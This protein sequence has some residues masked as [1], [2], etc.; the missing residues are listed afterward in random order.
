MMIFLMIITYFVFG[1]LI[2]SH[3]FNMSFE[4]AL[5]WTWSHFIDPGFISLDAT[6]I[7][8]R[9]FGSIFAILGMILVA[10]TIVNFI[11]NVTK[12]ILKEYADGHL[13][14]SLDNDI[15]VIGDYAKLI[16]FLKFDPRPILGLQSHVD[17]ILLATKTKDFEILRAAMDNGNDS[18]NK[19]IYH[20]S[21]EN[22]NHKQTLQLT[23]LST[24]I[25]FE[26][27][28]DNTGLMIGMIESIL[29]KRRL[30]HK[31]NI[32]INII[33]ESAKSMAILDLY[34][35]KNRDSLNENLMTITY[36]NSFVMNTRYFIKKS[37]FFDLGYLKMQEPIDFL[38]VIDGKNLFALEFLMQFLSLG[39]YHIKNT[40]INII[41]HDNDSFEKMIKSRIK[42]DLEVDDYAKKMIDIQ[43]YA[44][45]EQWYSSIMR[46]QANINTNISFS[47]FNEN[48]DDVV[49]KYISI[50]F[51]IKNINQAYTNLNQKLKVNSIFLQLSDDS[52]YR[53]Q[54]ELFYLE[55][56]QI[57]FIGSNIETLYNIA[58][59][60]DAAEKNH[61]QYLS[62]CNREKDS[63]GQY[64]RE[65]HN[66]WD[67][68]GNIQKD[69]NRSNTD[70]FSIK[71]QI[72][73]AY[74][75]LPEATLERQHHSN[76][77][78]LSPDFKAKAKAM[79]DFY[80][81]YKQEYDTEGTS[82][83]DVSQFHFESEQELEIAKLINQLA[84]IEHH[85]WSTERYVQGY[86]YADT[87]N[88]LLKKHNNLVDFQKLS[89]STKTFD[90]DPLIE[91][92]K[93]LI[94]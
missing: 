94:D 65:S 84:V 63:N 56:V 76:Q 62:K 24:I 64:K 40:K 15:L 46:S 66:D 61:Q 90:I 36:F 52:G 47:V 3:L 93:D 25:I 29:N 2:M 55:D 19:Y 45:I 32:K 53:N 59:I 72:I 48:D 58:W 81:K 6:P 80:T 35:N 49:E 8:R 26:K 91:K 85:R 79:I 67:K 88:D 37:S 13:P 34:I 17:L 11:G 12:A 7:S 68:L 74:F 9:I 33:L 60:D 41:N 83:Y 28:F 14:P 18:K 57:D 21:I 69:W 92:L 44:S 5:W 70:H 23:E 38:M 22:I 31:K 87:R 42:A 77:I 39:I 89:S 27:A 75:G 86:Q 71:L 54:R 4:D 73:Q 30:V 50:Y 82:I 1:I 43:Y 51:Y 78:K 20:C 16:S 10:Y